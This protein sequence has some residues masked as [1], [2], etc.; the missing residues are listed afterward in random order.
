VFSCKK[1]FAKD[2]ASSDCLGIYRL[3][4]VLSKNRQSEEKV[5]ISALYRER[6]YFF[7]EKTEPKNAD[8]GAGK[9]FTC[10]TKEYNICIRY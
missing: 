5:K 1:Y 8:F 7:A 3:T 10:L 4:S 6:W 9:L 2:P